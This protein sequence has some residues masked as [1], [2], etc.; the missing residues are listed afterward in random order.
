MNADSLLS[1]GFPSISTPVGIDLANDWKIS[2]KFLPPLEGDTC[3]LGGLGLEMGVRTFVSGFKLVVRHFRACAAGV[4]MPD[5]APKVIPTACCWLMLVE[6]GL[7]L[8]G[9]T[10]LLALKKLWPA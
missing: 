8:V 6:L 7:S 9:L 1:V 2:M 10:L 3:G 5:D 4:E